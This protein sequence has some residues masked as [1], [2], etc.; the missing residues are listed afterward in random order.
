MRSIAFYCILPKDILILTKLS[1]FFLQKWLTK[2]KQFTN[3]AHLS[4][5][6]KQYK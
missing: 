6:T 5:N 2:I 1:T 4:D 3:W